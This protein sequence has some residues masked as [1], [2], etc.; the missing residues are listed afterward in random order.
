MAGYAF[1]L[2]NDKVTEALEATQIRTVK[3]YLEALAAVITG[4]PDWVNI[5]LVV[6]IKKVANYWIETGESDYE[7]LAKIAA[8][9]LALS[10]MHEENRADAMAEGIQQAICR[11][12][13]AQ[14]F[15]VD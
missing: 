10:K 6:N 12:F 5:G 2:L 4:Q 14:V 15:F 8:L 3:I 1:T 9:T 11:V 7:L 13:K